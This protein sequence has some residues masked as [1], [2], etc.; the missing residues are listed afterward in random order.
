M[1]H[2]KSTM[3]FLCAAFASALLLLSGCQKTADGEETPAPLSGAGS[4][5]ADP[6]G[7]QADTAVSGGAQADTSVSGSARAAGAS[8]HADEILAQMSGTFKQSYSPDT[9]YDVYLADGFCESRT[10]GMTTDEIRFESYY[11]CGTSGAEIR[12][13][14]LDGSGGYILTYI[15]AV[16]NNEYETDETRPA[17]GTIV[18]ADWNIGVLTYRTASQVSEYAYYTGMYEEYF[19]EDGYTCRYLYDDQGNTCFLFGYKQP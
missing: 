2:T 3:L 19:Y 1:N 18:E 15:Y 14:D 4:N 11:F 16:N 13:I 9:G 5:A 17:S 7:V 8:V 10:E 12:R 6:S